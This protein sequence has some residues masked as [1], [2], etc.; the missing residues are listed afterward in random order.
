MGDL[1]TPL[2]QYDYI[3]TDYYEKAVK[4]YS[5]LIGE[6]LM[7]FS[8]LEHEL[9]IAVAEIV[10]DR[11]HDVGYLVVQKI[12][13]TADKIDLFYKYYKMFEYLTDRQTKELKRIFDSLVEINEFRNKIAHVKW[14]SMQKNGIVRYK[15][16]STKKTGEIRFQNIII[17]SKDI[18]DKI[19]EIDRVIDKIDEYREK[20]YQF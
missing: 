17:Q 18:R 5:K 19:K 16:R 4:K 11:S 3:D 6:F 15:I 8:Y 2:E 7:D 9:E 20:I 13:K 14:C 1:S 10:N 12:E